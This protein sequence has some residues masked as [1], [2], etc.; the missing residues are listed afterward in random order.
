MWFQVKFGTMA[1]DFKSFN[2]SWH[3]TGFWQPGRVPELARLTSLAVNWDK[4]G[5]IV[6]ELMLAWLRTNQY[7]DFELTE[8]PPIADLDSEYLISSWL[9]KFILQSISSWLNYCGLVNK[10]KHDLSLILTNHTVLY[11]EMHLWKWPLLSVSSSC[12]SHCP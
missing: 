9:G 3:H 12:K 8:I 5:N 2:S 1:A 6:W 11:S 7:G 4:C 10:Y